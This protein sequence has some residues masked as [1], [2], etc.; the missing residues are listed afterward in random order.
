MR[1][2]NQDKIVAQIYLRDWSMKAEILRKAQMYEDTIMHSEHKNDDC[3]SNNIHSDGR[4]ITSGSLDNGSNENIKLYAPTLHCNRSGIYLEKGTARVATTKTSSSTENGDNNKSS[5]NNNNDN[6]NNAVNDN[7]I[8][9]NDSANSDDM[10]VS[11]KFKSNKIRR[12]SKKEQ[13]LKMRKYK[14]IFNMIKPMIAI[15]KL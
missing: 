3:T 15:D 13:V 2:S 5:S 10:T 9:D 8:C 12:S 6:S 1:R 11:L 14:D 7:K 4:Q